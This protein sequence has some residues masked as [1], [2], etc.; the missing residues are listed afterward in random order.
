[1]G[2]Y[3]T[4]CSSTSVYRDHDLQRIDV[5]LLVT[6][7]FD[8]NTL[9][10]LFALIPMVLQCKSGVIEIDSSYNVCGKTQ[11]LIVRR[12]CGMRK[13]TRHIGEVTDGTISNIMEV[14][15]VEHSGSSTTLDT[16]SSTNCN[17]NDNP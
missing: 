3:S 17:K 1:M 4:L 7:I 10:T 14:V 6:Q 12:Q 2:L 5:T 11:L 13:I 16:G 15:K 8:T 9:T